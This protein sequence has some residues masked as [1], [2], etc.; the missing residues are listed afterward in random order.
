MNYSLNEITGGEH[1]RRIKKGI[2]KARAE[3]RR[4]GRPRLL[5]P[6]QV[7]YALRLRAT[8][9]LTLSATANEMGVGASTLRKYF[10]E[11]K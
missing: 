9:R 10:K 8:R 5:T 4:P 11:A 1:G 6:A 7:A 3:G 2:A